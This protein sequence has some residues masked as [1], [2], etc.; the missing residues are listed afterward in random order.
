MPFIENEGL[1]IYYEF[2]AGSAP[3]LVFIHGWTANMNFWEEQRAHFRG[4]N[5][6]LFIDNRGHGK[7]DKPKKYDFYRL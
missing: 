7:S 5:T 6:L 2:E 3:T 1:K 4:K